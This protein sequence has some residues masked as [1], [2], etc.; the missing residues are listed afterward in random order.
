MTAFIIRSPFFSH[1]LNRS[2]INSFDASTVELQLAASETGPV[3]KG[4]V[5]NDKKI[6]LKNGGEF[7]LRIV[8]HTVN[9]HFIIWIL[10]QPD[11]ARNKHEVVQYE[12]H[13]S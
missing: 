13:G 9:R 5:K 12:L 4:G 8:C 3:I 10:T 11:Y 1:A 2:S 6:D 7:M